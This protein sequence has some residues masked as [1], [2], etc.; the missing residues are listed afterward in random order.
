MYRQ[1]GVQQLRP[2]EDRHSS[3]SQAAAANAP[4]QWV[5]L[6]A[7]ALYRYALLRVRDPSVA[8][9]LVQETFLAGLRSRERFAERSSE[10]TWLTGILKHRLVDFMRRA[11]RERPDPVAATEHELDG[12]FSRRGKWK[13]APRTWRD[14]EQAF[15]QEELRQVLHNCLSALPVPLASA[16]TL[17]EL[18]E[19]QADQI[20]NILNVTATNLWTLLHRAR[21]RLRDC[22]ETNW[23]RAKQ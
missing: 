5:E 9:D 10:R 7:P 1:H 3:P 11:A 13:R 16:I 21:T 4:E 12:F 20:C 17:R 23:F 2:T 22:L 8:E 18:S 15:D 14:P 19:L 6:H